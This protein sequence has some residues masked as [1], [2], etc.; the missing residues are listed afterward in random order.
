MVD[1][2]NTEGLE[3]LCDNLRDLDIVAFIDQ[4]DVFSHTYEE[5]EKKM[6]VSF[7]PK[8]K[9]FGFRFVNSTN[10]ELVGKPSPQDR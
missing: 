2:P 10:D 7:M 3:D 6:R 8:D 5:R 1:V 4:E 9:E